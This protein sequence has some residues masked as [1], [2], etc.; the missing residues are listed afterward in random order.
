MIYHN[1]LVKTFNVKVQIYQ[2]CKNLIIGYSSYFYR[3]LK[4]KK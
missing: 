3:N 4:A 2:K 1:F